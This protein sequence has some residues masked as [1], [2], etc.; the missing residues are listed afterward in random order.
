MLFTKPRSPFIGSNLPD[1]FFENPS[2]FPEHYNQNIKVD[3]WKMD[4][5][6]KKN[7]ELQFSLI[8]W[9]SIPLLRFVVVLCSKA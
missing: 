3:R 9:Q 7:F 8:S 6:I 5:Y 1:D 4:H 2:K